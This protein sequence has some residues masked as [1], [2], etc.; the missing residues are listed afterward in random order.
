MNKQTTLFSFKL[1]PT[2]LHW[3]AGAFSITSLPLPEHPFHS[4]KAVQQK[5]QLLQGLNSLRERGLVRGSAATSWQVDRLPA[6]IVNWFGSA[7]RMLIL[8]VHARDGGVRR[9]H[10]CTENDV[11]V[12]VTVEGDTYHFLFFPNCGALTEYLLDQFGAS[13]S[14]PRTAAAQYAFPQPVTIL[15]SAWTDASLAAKMLKVSR[16]KPKEIKSLLA[17]AGSLEW[18]VTLDHIQL[19]GEEAGRDSQTILCG[20]RQRCWSGRAG[21]DSDEAVTLSPINLVETQALIQNL[22]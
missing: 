21:G 12:Y 20:N 10:V 16:L 6:A 8:N 17:W 7:A 19:D 3:L 9:A 15:R 11:S 1:S 22:L 5:P 18:I 13:F 2:E 4:I 14:D